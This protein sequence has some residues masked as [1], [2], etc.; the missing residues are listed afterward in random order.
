MIVTVPADWVTVS[1]GKLESVT[2]A[3]QGM[4]TWTWRQAQPVSTYLISLV[5]GE[6]D[7]SKQTWHN[8]PVDYYVP[9]G[10]RERI[11]PTF[12]RTRDMLTYFS[13]RLGVPY[14]WVKY[15]QSMVDQFVEGGMENV[16]ATTLTTR[17]LLHPALAR[18][19]LEGSDNLISHE[20]S[21]QWFGDLVTTKDWANLWLNEGFATFMAQLWEEHQYGVDNAAYSAVALAGGVDAPDGSS[22]CRWSRATFTDSMEYAGNIYGKAG[23]VLEMLREQLGDDAF[24]HGLQHYLEDQSARKRGHRRSGARARG[25]DAL[26]L[27]RFFDQWIYGAARPRFAVTSTYDSAA[28]PAPRTSSRRRTCVARSAV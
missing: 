3:R 19:S 6:F 7:Y 4:K 16:S 10:G 12:A 28:E 1:N 8:I 24:F 25:V 11:A 2:D 27:D 5:A 23:L 17:G 14:P 15:D 26:N 9:H 13:D 18:E 21:H 20:M 22:R